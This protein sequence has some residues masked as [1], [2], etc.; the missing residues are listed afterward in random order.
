MDNQ[1]DVGLLNFSNPGEI[2]IRLV[3]TMGVNATEGGI[4]Q[5][6]TGLK[7]AIAGVLRLGGRIVV[8]SGETRLDFL[9]VPQTI[10]GKEFDF[11]EMVVDEPRNKLAPR[12][13]VLGFTTELGKHWEPW[14]LY[15]ELFA[16]SRDAGGGGIAETLRVGG[17]N[18]SIGSPG[19]TNV[20]VQ[21][22]ELWGIH[23]SREEFFIAATEQPLW[24]GHGVE[25]FPANA[26]NGGIFYQGIRVQQTPDAVFRYSLTERVALTEDRTL[27]DSYGVWAT[28][29][30]A[31]VRCDSLTVLIAA[32]TPDVHEAGLDFD[33]YSLGRPSEEFIHAGLAG[34]RE[35]N[36][37]SLRTV[38]RRHAPGQ[39][40]VAELALPEP[41]ATFAELLAEAPEASTEVPSS[42]NFWSYCS[43][44][45]TLLAA[46]R[47]RGDY[48]FAIAA[49]LAVARGD[50]EASSEASHSAPPPDNLEPF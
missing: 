17:F 1:M 37:D 45:E 9:T 18:M 28:V 24:S 26:G 8:W 50:C 16:N 20:T 44:M 6:G 47:K 39:L 5:F 25:I 49:R 34:V 43:E 29:A 35:L 48:W 15:R 14:M 36:N 22:K 38:L 13:H 31:L 27:A 11:I 3:T 30:K 32:L 19:E 21:C 4:G 10:K 23:A 33:W 40:A 12:S 7:Y 2:D 46:A 42:P 41:G